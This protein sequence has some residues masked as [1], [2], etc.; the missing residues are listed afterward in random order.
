MMRIINKFK[1]GRELK[2]QGAA[3]QELKSLLDIASRVA[4]TAKTPLPSP[5]RKQQLLDSIVGPSVHSKSRPVLRY[6]TAFAACFVVLLSGTAAYAQNSLPG[7]RLY[8]IKRT[9]ED[10]RLWFQPSYAHHLVDERESE[11]D[12]LK[13]KG[14]SEDK[15]HKAEDELKHAQEE[16][17][18]V[19]GDN[20]EGQNKSGDDGGSSDESSG[21]GTSGSS[22][23]SGSSSSSD[24][25][26]S[27]SGGHGSDD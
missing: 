12:S 5:E 10:V 3:G 17:H 24:T 22:S 7:S 16:A 8:G 6:A 1:L 18:H 26:G 9:S 27:S 21:S 2:A 20:V 11:L 23:G 13:H 14:E 25:S 15:I 4:Q 19:E